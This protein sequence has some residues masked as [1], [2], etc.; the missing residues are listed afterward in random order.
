MAKGVAAK[1]NLAQECSFFEIAN[2]AWT[3]NTLD[4]WVRHV[5]DTQAHK[6]S[7]MGY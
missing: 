5:E 6:Q 1:L 7:K 3:W 2:S 4:F